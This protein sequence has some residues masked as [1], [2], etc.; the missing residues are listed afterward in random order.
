M[1]LLKES[2]I[3]LRRIHNIL[4]KNNTPVRYLW[5][6]PTD[7]LGLPEAL[8]VKHPPAKEGDIRDTGSFPGSGRSC[9]EGNSNP[10]QCSCLEKP[11]DRRA[12]WATVHGVTKEPNT[13]E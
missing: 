10:L 13:T 9:G 12:W 4:K 8:V 6:P 11:M 7:R 3:Y 1:G 5:V 2:G